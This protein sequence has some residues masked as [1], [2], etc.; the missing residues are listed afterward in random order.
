[1]KTRKPAPLPVIDLAGSVKVIDDTT[2]PP[3]WKTIGRV[4]AATVVN[5]K[6]VLKAHNLASGWL[7]NDL[8]EKEFVT[9]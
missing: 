8:G 4:P 1:M 9:V 5:A 6:R 2:A 3:K 7:F